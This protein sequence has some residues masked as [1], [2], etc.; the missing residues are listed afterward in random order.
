MA[1]KNF[2]ILKNPR[3]LR[4]KWTANKIPLNSAFVKLNSHTHTQKQNFDGSLD[5]FHSK[6]I[7]GNFPFW[8]SDDHNKKNV[9][10]FVIIKI[11]SFIF[12]LLN[13]FLK[14]YI[15]F[16]KIAAKHLLKREQIWQFYIV[17]NYLT[18]NNFLNLESR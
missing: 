3:L 6:R 15:L 16:F 7:N 1:L 8:L 10:N 5:F 2:M 18:G 13:L 12:S 11:Y 9:H 4:N 14:T 17:M